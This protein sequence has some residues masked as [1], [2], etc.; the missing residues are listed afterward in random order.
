[1]TALPPAAEATQISDLEPNALSA[2]NVCLAFEHDAKTEKDVVRARLLGYLILHAPSLDALHEVVRVIHS[3]SDDYNTLSDLGE[4]FINVFIRPFKKYKGR[5]PDYSEYSSHRSLIKDKMDLMTAI[6]EASK[7]HKEAKIQALIRDG[8]KCV[9][10]GKYDIEA[11]RIPSIDKAEIRRVRAIHTE[12]AHIV[13]EST[14]FDVSRT[15]SPEKKDYAASLLAV[16]K[17]FGYDVEKLNDA[18]MHSLYNVM[19]MQKDVREWF[20]RLE[21]WFEATTVENCYRVKTFDEFNEYLDIPAAVTLTSSN[22]TTLPLPSPEL[23]AL[24]AACA[25]VAHLSGAGAYIDELDGDLEDLDVLAD[26]GGS[27]DVLNHALSRLMTDSVN[28]GAKCCYDAAP[29]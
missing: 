22:P 6:Q 10:T 7:D 24:H 28:V 14:F 26:D 21:M 18:K 20:D 29:M 4:C 16:L 27:A 19:T 15:S 17:R 2:Y 3:C 13:P 23:L 8:F 9:V 12:C 5:T 1:M 25:K 11:V